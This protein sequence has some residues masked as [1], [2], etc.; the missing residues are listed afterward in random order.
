[1]LMMF[2]GVVLAFVCEETLQRSPRYVALFSL[3]GD[4]KQPVGMTS[5]SQGARGSPTTEGIRRDRTNLE[6]G[7]FL[8]QE[9]LELS[10]L[11]GLVR[12][13]RIRAE[14]QIFHRA[15]EATMEKERPSLA[16]R[17]VFSERRLVLP[18]CYVNNLCRL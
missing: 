4:V 6:K 10:N 11:A 17:E 16:N 1:M 18:K 15:I 9:D 5:V 12:P 14:L 2:V 3:V 8:R 13:N 7:A